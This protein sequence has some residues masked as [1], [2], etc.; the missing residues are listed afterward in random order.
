MWTIK[1]AFVAE[2]ALLA[3]VAED[4]LF[5][6]FFDLE[7]AATSVRSEA[8]KL[9][10]STLE[11]IYSKA[12]VL[13]ETARILLDS[14]SPFQGTQELLGVRF[15]PDVNP[16]ANITNFDVALADTEVREVEEKVGKAEVEKVPK[17]V[18]ERADTEGKVGAVEV[19]EAREED[20][21]GGG[22]RRGKG[23]TDEVAHSEVREVR[24]A[25]VV[26]GCKVE[27]EELLV[28]EVMVVE[29]GVVMEAKVGVVEG[30]G[31][32]MS[33]HHLWTDV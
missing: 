5:A 22:G 3:F 33:S 8:N 20:L 11:L 4:A 17:V 21:A 7:D 30:E 19:T 27:V 25:R 2:D 24:V 16:H 23:D 14:G 18:E 1:E 29:K 32:S 9:L 26:E 31:V 15:L 12:R 13:L 28:V 10:F 6:T